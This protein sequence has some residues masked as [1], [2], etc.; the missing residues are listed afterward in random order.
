MKNMTRKNERYMY[1]GISFVFPWNKT[2]CLPGKENKKEC[3]SSYFHRTTCTHRNSKKIKKDFNS[4]LTKYS[5][6]S[7]PASSHFPASQPAKKEIYEERFFL[8]SHSK[9]NKKKPHPL[10]PPKSHLRLKIDKKQFTSYSKLLLHQAELILTNFSINPPF[11]FSPSSP[12]C[13]LYRFSPSEGAPATAAPSSSP[14]ACPVPSHTP[15]EEFL[16]TGHSTLLHSDWSR[17]TAY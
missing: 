8:L 6:P 11:S 2:I 14:P 1:Q 5:K 17:A 12:P 9:S 7:L 10:P 4:F 16:A 15:A 3:L 13:P